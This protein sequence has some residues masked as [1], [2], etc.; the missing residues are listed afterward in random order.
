[1]I[2]LKDVTFIVPLRLDSNDRIFNFTYVVSYLCRHFDTNIF[3][4]ESDKAPIAQKLLSRI[5]PHKTK[6]SYRFEKCDNSIFHRTRILNEL[7]WEVKTPVVVNQD[8][9]VFLDIP[10]YTQ[11][12][13]AVLAGADLV[14]PYFKGLSQKKIHRPTISSDLTQEIKHEMGQSVCGHLQFLNTEKYKEFGGECEDFLS[15]APEDSERMERFQKLGKVEWLGNFVYHIEHSR[16]QNSGKDNPHYDANEQLYKQISALTPDQLRAYYKVVP[17][18]KKYRARMITL[19]TYADGKYKEQQKKIISR[20]LSLG[21]VD[22]TIEAD[23]RRIAESE[24]YVKHKDILDQ[25]RGNGYWIWKP[26]LILETLINMPE[27]DI[28]VYIDSGDWISSSFRD[29]I[30]R[31]MRTHDFMLTEGSYPCSEYT[32]RDV[33]VAMGCDEEKYWSALQVEAGIIV[34][35]K[36]EAT[37]HVLRE[38]LKW[39]LT[40]GLV[41]DA[42]SKAKNLPDFID[43][44]HDQSILSLMRV[45]HKLECT[46]EMRRYV[47]CNQ[48]PS[49]E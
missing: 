27:D 38:W 44:R 31:K 28:L 25:P 40:P 5:N 24:F 37:I 17:Y 23:R 49:E 43:S 6:I 42:P 32:K 39:C 36:T 29:F 10:A 7:L 14:Y 35:K 22:Y 46:N 48:Q 8:C 21:T 18:I 15:W 47:N 12:R 3:I 30:I 26:H 33:F 13:D 45:F 1:M 11:A 19:L 41:T 16:G 20:A 4:L 34:C 9:D 2:S